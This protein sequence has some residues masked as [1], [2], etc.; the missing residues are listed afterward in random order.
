MAYLTAAQ[1]LR[2]YDERR[3]RQLLSDSGS[4]T[5]GDL[6]TDDNL[7]DLLSMASEMIAAA[8]LVGKRYTLDQLTELATSTSYGFLLRQ[9]T[10]DLAYGLLVARR[11]TSAADLTR[12]APTYALALQQL[13]M[14][15]NGH[16]LFP[17]LSNDQHPD[18]DLPAF[19]DAKDANNPN[20]QTFFTDTSYRL[21][22]FS[23]RRD[24]G[25]GPGP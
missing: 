2:K 22:P 10:A 7:S 16:C 23:Q 12:L 9:L 17:G 24:P 8:V 15:R 21:F 11:G 25:L 19:T 4:P 6:A 5:A 20:R 18:A 13:E 3:V 14:L 1:F